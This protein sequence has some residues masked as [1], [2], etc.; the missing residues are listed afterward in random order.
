MHR[1]WNYILGVFL[2]WSLDHDNYINENFFLCQLQNKT[3]EPQK[4]EE[5]CFYTSNQQFSK[6]WCFNID[7]LLKVF[8]KY[9]MNLIQHK[10]ILLKKFLD[11]K[12]IPFTEK[13]LKLAKFHRLHCWRIKID[14]ES[15]D[16]LL[17]SLKKGKE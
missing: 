9:L 12:C 11:L 4:Y 6:K 7:H 8:T 1:W 17:P 14:S 2:K 10:R 5:S 16:H 13:Q 15:I 3:L